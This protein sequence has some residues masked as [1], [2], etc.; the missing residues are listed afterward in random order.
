MTWSLVTCERD[1]APAMAVLRSDGLVVAPRDLKRWTSTLELLEEWPEAEE[2]L[3][4]IDVEDAPVVETSA[5]LAP[6]RWPRKVICAGVNYRRHIEEMGAE[7]PAEGWTPFF[8]LKAPTTTVIGPSDSITI[9][10]PETARFDWEVELAA[11]IGLGGRDISEND[12]LSHVAGY[13][14]ANDISARGLH[15]RDVVP[16]E[17]FSYDWFASKSADDSL[18]LGPGITPAFQVADPQDLHLRLWVNGE[19]QQD[20]T[21]ADM[22]C[23][24]AELISS[25]SGVVTLEPGDVILTGTPS[26]VGAG[27]GLYLHPGDVIRA[28]IDGLGTI[29]NAVVDR[30]E[31]KP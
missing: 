10:R 5:L 26:G 21:T 2:V 24:V 17:P 20:E 13:C 1:G 22:I 29:E 4:S 18:P 12:A 23:T 3:R 7:V 19:L 31:R 16:A 8:F 15:H 14:V 28:S 27:R 30:S 11:V 9:D 25:A 6:L